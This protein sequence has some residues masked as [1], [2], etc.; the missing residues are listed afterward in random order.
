MGTPI[1][2]PFL[3]EEIGILV[4]CA[5]SRPGPSGHTR[6]VVERMK[7]HVQRLIRAGLLEEDPGTKGIYRVTVKG[8]ERITP[9]LRNRV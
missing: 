9:F 6:L 4:L 7:P 1:T 3:P 8:E 5:Y 2:R